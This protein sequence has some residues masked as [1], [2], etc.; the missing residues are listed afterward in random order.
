MAVVICDLPVLWRSVATSL[1][2]QGQDN[3]QPGNS[4]CPS[5]STSLQQAAEYFVSGKCVGCSENRYCSIL[6]RLF[7]KLQEA[8]PLAEYCELRNRFFSCNACLRRILIGACKRSVRC[9]CSFFKGVE[10]VAVFGEGSVFTYKN[11][12]SFFTV[13]G[14]HSSSFSRSVGGNGQIFKIQQKTLVVWSQEGRRTDMAGWKREQIIR[15]LGEELF[16]RRQNA[17]R[18]RKEEE[19]F[20]GRATFEMREVWPEETSPIVKKKPQRGGPRKG[21]GR[22]KGLRN[23]ESRKREIP[24]GRV[25]RRVLLSDL[26]SSEVC[27]NLRRIG[28]NNVDQLSRFGIANLRGVLGDKIA[29]RVWNELSKRS[30]TFIGS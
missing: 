24:I 29:I 26:A 25:S 23:K 14:N 30:Q 9:N 16:L 28:I 8:L 11:C 27:R 10:R 5:Q 15:R 22:P 2:L 18:E 7:A 17:K 3:S 1:I 6:K 20:E 13:V 19:W 4:C 12:S 21:A